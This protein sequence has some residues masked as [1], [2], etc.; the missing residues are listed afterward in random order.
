[1]NIGPHSNELHRN[2]ELDHHNLELDLLLRV[3]LQEVDLNLVDGPHV[4]FGLENQ[5]HMHLRF[6]QALSFHQCHSNEVCL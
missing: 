2:L 5:L 3:Q 4:N 1:M 6:L